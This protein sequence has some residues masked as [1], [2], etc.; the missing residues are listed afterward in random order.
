VDKFIE[1]LLSQLVALATF[2]AFPAIQYVLLKII[3]KKE[4]NPELWYLPARGFRLVIRNKPRKKILKDIKYNI[5]LIKIIQPSEG[6][7]IATTDINYIRKGE[8][9]FLF[10]GADHILLNFKLQSSINGDISFVYTD[11]I[12]NIINNLQLSNL[13]GVRCD[14]S[15][16]IQNFFNFNIQF[17]KMVYISASMIQQLFDDI[18]NNNSE[19]KF[20]LD[21]IKNIG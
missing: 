11:E 8:K 2:F 21:N 16:I 6:C 19:K 14:Y 12:G 20:N 10:P 7:D 13:S 5:A 1:Q 18:K 9:L 15:S 4:G 3:S 17:G